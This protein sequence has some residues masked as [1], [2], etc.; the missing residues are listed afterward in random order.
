MEEDE[1]ILKFIS[2]EKIEIKGVSVGTQFRLL[3][4]IEN[5]INKYKEL[6]KERDGIYADY[7]EL[8]K[9][10][11]ELEEKLDNVF[12]VLRIY[13]NE[14]VSKY[15]IRKKIKELENCIEKWRNEKEKPKEQ[16][17]K[18]IMRLAAEIGILEALLIGDDIDE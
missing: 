11:L 5:L 4:R 8:G 2:E 14:C 16:C 1:Q 15:K 12:H 9:E 10:K 13:E 17:N 6:E 18:E 7:Q 3:R